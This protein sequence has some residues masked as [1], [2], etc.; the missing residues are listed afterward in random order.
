MLQGLA[1]ED[2]EAIVR[3]LST[4]VDP[5]LPLL[6]G[7]RKR[8]LAEGLAR[9]VGADVWIWTSSVHSNQVAGDAMTVNILDG[10][11]RDEAQRVALYRFLSEPETAVPAGKPITEK[12]QQQRHFTVDHGIIP[13]EVWETVQDRYYA[14]GLR[15]CLLSIY[16]LDE[17]SFSGL[18]LHRSDDRPFQDR[19]RVIVH[20]VFSQVDWLHRQG[21]DIPAR[22]N[23]LRLTPRQRQILI[24]LLSGESTSKIA[25]KL[26]LSE[27][28]IN[29]HIRHLFER[30]KVDSRASLLAQFMSCGD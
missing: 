20:T 26:E 21:T 27:H 7:E 1:V 12:A 8:R 22:D 9:L 6:L 23:V 30:L 15:H 28:T 18:G 17:R 11:W 14:T 19:E 25:D 10:G 24:F 13:P 16:P 4:T 2:V 29:Y 3:L 5:H